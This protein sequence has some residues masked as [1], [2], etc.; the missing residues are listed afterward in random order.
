MTRKH[1]NELSARFGMDLAAIRT[2]EAYNV[3]GAQSARSG[4][5]DAVAAIVDTLRAD[6][7]RFDRE[8]FYDAVNKAEAKA[9]ER[10]GVTA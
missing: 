6:N 5:L 1:Y 10:Y 2:S 9:A 3:A 7:P 4:Y 8:R